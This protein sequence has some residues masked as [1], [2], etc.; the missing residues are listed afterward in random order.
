MIRLLIAAGSA[1]VRAG[2]EALAVSSGAIELVGAF[3]DLAAVDDLRPDVV[4][5]AVT[6]EQIPAG[7]GVRPAYVLLGGDARTPWTQEAIRSGVRAILPRDAS[8]AEILAAVEAAAAGMAAIGPAELEALLPAAASVAASNE[9]PTL[10]PRELEVLAMMAEGAANKAIA[11]KLNI[12]EHTAKFHVASVLSKL[13]A[14]TRAEAVAIGIRRG[15]V[16]L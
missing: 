2:L 7:D 8:A 16:M 14:S 1:V 3:P 6:P 5:A 10:T 11:W 4:L 12:S 9:N 15:L 13:N